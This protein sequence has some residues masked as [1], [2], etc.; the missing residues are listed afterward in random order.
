M[1]KIVLMALGAVALYQVAKRNGINSF[2]DLKDKFKSFIGDLNL[3]ELVNVDK[4]K[5]MVGLGEE[6]LATA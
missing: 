2:G 6:E 5:T 1:K 4:L 3:R